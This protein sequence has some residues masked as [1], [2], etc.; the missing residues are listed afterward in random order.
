MSGVS[1][2]ML[3]NMLQVHGTQ[4]APQARG[5]G[6][7]LFA[8]RLFIGQAIGVPLAAPV[9]DRWGA[10]S[11][12]WTAAIVLPAL[13]LWLARAIRRR[14]ARVIAHAHKK[15]NE[16]KFLRLVRSISL[17]L[18]DLAESGLRSDIAVLRSGSLLRLGS[19]WR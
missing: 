8:L 9:V 6:M 19:P 7:A 13:A 1:F 18:E 10:T 4:M 12:F 3:H 5:P 17:F 16:A 11:V 15:H 2:N 14:A